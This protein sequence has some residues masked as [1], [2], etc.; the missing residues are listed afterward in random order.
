M[1]RQ[2]REFAKLW[3]AHL[4]RAQDRTGLFVKDLAT[5]LGVVRTTLSDGKSRPHGVGYDLVEGIATFAELN[6]EERAVFYNAYIRMRATKGT[7]GPV[8]TVLLDNL[9]ESPRA[10]RTST[11]ITAFRA[12]LKTAKKR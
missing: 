4:K 5:K 9:D 6:D 12:L 3:S 7:L 8:V 2:E 10:S 11:I 1:T